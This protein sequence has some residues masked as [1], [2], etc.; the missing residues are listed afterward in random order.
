MSSKFV[1]LDVCDS[2]TPSTFNQRSKI[3]I[4][5]SLFYIHILPYCNYT[6]KCFNDKIII[7]A[8]INDIFQIM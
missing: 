6:V 4:V 1:V 5:S 3:I 8:E 7:N 2:P